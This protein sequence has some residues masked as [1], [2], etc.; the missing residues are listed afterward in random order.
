VKTR[1]WAISRKI[2]LLGIVS[3]TAGT[4]IYKFSGGYSAAEEEN[5]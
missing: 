4:E 1:A 2:A 3:P 5:Q